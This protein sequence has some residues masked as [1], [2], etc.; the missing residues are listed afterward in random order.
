MLRIMKKILLKM[1]KKEA[2]EKVLEEKTNRD[3]KLIEKM[4]KRGDAIS[5]IAD[6]LEI[7]VEEVENAK[8]ELKL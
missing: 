3:K 7:P 8:K 5:K 2:E 4:L 1:L 6:F